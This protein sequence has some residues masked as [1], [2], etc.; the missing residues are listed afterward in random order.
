[1]SSTAPTPPSSL[2]SSSST[3]RTGLRATRRSPGGGRLNTYRIRSCDRGHC[4]ERWQGR[5]QSVL[6]IVAPSRQ[7][8]LFSR[9]C[10]R[11]DPYGSYGNDFL[12]AARRSGE[13]NRR[14]HS[15][16]RLSKL[17][18]IHY[19]K[20]LLSVRVVLCLP[21]CFECRAVRTWACER[22]AADG[23]SR[24][25]AAVASPGCRAFQVINNRLPSVGRQPEASRG[26]LVCFSFK[27]PR[28]HTSTVRRLL[29]SST[30]T[31]CGCHN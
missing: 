29:R 26:H 12:R 10:S 11:P 6:G 8:Y 15:M 3:R 7:E 25:Q 31:A 30:T 2:C 27:K 23:R 14:A 22:R 4:D 1:M 13:K 16:L 28:D 18:H 24:S 20:T 21:A 5:I 17:A 19:Y 9:E